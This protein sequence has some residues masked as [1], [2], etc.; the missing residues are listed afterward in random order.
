MISKNKL[1]TILDIIPLHTGKYGTDDF[2]NRV[3]SI[4]KLYEIIDLLDEEDEKIT[5]IKEKIKNQIESCQNGAN[6]IEVS[7]WN[8]ALRTAINIIDEVMK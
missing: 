5:I 4:D 6:D 2:D 8:N 3:I 7:Y 1:K